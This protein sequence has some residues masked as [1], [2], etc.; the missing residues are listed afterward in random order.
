MQ[1]CSTLARCLFSNATYL[2]R[3]EGLDAVWLGYIVDMSIRFL[4]KCT[5]SILVF[6]AL[7][8]IQQSLNVYK[9]TAANSSF[10]VADVAVSNS[11]MHGENFACA[12]VTGGK[13]K[14]WGITTTF[15]SGWGFDY[16]LGDG[17]TLRSA[18]PTGS[19]YG[20]YRSVVTSEIMSCGVQANDDMRCWGGTPKTGTYDSIRSLFEWEQ[21][22]TQSVF[23][24]GVKS[25]VL[26]DLSGCVILADKSVKCW[27]WNVSG[28]LGIGS[29]SSSDTPVSVPGLSNVAKISAGNRTFCALSETGLV[30]CWG[31]NYSG[32]LGNTTFNRELSPYPL[33]GA[34]NVSDVSTSGNSTCV[35]ISGLVKCIGGND[36]GQLGD[37]TTAGRRSLVQV[38]GVTNAVAVSVGESG[39]TCALLA[40]QTVK[41][42]GN[43]SLGQLGDGTKVNRLSPTAVDGLTSVTKISTGGVSSCAIISDATVRCWGNNSFG[44]LGDGSTTERLKPVSVLNENIISFSAIPNKTIGDEFFEISGVASSGEQVKFASSGS[45][46]VF[47]Y[48]VSIVSTG[49]CTVTASEKGNAFYG[50]AQD[51]TRSF[52]VASWNS[53]RANIQTKLRFT[54]SNGNPISNLSVSWSTVGGGDQAS[55][56][57]KI[58]NLNGEVLF[59]AVSG[60]ARISAGN[61]ASQTEIMSNPDRP[62]IH[63]FN[64]VKNLVQG[65]VSIN[66]GV[67]PTVTTRKVQVL[68]SDGTPVRDAVVV[69]G[70]FVSPSNQESKG[71]SVLTSFKMQNSRSYWRSSGYLGGM[72]TLQYCGRDAIPGTGQSS[73]PP[74]AKTGSDGFAEL[75]GFPVSDSNRAP[76]EVFGDS[77]TSCYNDGELNQ[78]KV[79]TYVSDGITKIVLGYLAKV[80]IDALDQTVTEGSSVDIPV[81]AVDGLG[82]PQ[83]NKSMTLVEENSDGI[84]ASAAEARTTGVEKFG[85]SCT[86]SSTGSTNGSGTALMRICPTKSGRWYVKSSGSIS[87]RSIRITVVPKAGQVPASAGP[88][89]GVSNAGQVPASAGPISGVSNAGSKPLVFS[90]KKPTSAKSIAALAKLK[91]LSTS[92]VSLKVVAASAKYCKVSG[93]KLKGLKTGTCKVK[94]TVTPKK[95]RAS[96]KTVS[97]KV[98]K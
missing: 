40:D 20:E 94:V 42:W 78:T 49:I 12:V 9:T 46:S 6:A 62:I 25:V 48:E 47:G 24:G 51:V 35:V 37:G 44:A 32:L 1:D 92:K 5:A 75:N 17:S 19:T 85:S 90:V 70:A 29:T 21:R 27:G 39:H 95:G 80:T 57:N 34:S 63:N 30:H 4:V 72:E 87:S 64:V 13:I 10:T 41:C 53:Q 74:Q 52:N 23:L 79:T 69:A 98:T 56:S 73:Y 31:E 67:T 43:N 65:E 38:A 76:G 36:Y 89:S 58:T 28:Q 54:D 14:C 18:S 26:G 3:G 88:I 86:P 77:I 84:T 71:S 96:S 61:S 68:L 91:V 2:N 15:N 8:T 45:C 82:E 50:A 33:P 16:K 83:P 55:G 93:T 59:A 66:V 11:T 22:S 60:P 7:T 97:L 81:K